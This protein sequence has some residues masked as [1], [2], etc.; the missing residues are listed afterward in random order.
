MLTAFAL[1]LGACGGTPQADVSDAGLVVEL[2]DFTVKP[3]VDTLKAGKV[4]IGIRNLSG[5]VHELVVLK[6]TLAHDKLTIDGSSATAK[7]DGK[8]GALLNIGAGRVAALTVDLTPGSYV[9]ICNV[10][11]HYQ[12]GMR[13]ALKVE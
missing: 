9:L 6:T 1:V 11:G 8:V 7:D 10:A 12:L 2:R 5:M 4:K 13:A 3:S